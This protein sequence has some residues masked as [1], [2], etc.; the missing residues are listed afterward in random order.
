MKLCVQSVT[1]LLSITTPSIN[2]WY[3]DYVLVLYVQIKILVYVSRHTCNPSHLPCTRP[4][5]PTLWY[6]SSV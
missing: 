4:A 1:T 6:A 3:H 2:V 5:S